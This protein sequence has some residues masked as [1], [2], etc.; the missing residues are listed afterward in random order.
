MNIAAFNAMQT[1]LRIS[2][3]SA[4]IAIR[5]AQRTALNSS[6]QAA[7]TA[8]RTSSRNAANLTSHSTAE[9]RPK[10]RYR[11]SEESLRK[12]HELKAEDTKTSSGS[13]IT[14][15]KEGDKLI[16]KARNEKGE[17]E[18]KSERVLNKDASL[19]DITDTVLEGLKE[20]KE[21]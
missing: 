13:G 10:L 8:L 20:A 12:L 11:A 6:R 1:A 7:R 17:W 19:L 15:C 5:N 4:H 18:T 21:R 3:T 9:Q 14:M 16:F 2:Q